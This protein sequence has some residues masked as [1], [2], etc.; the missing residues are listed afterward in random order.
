MRTMTSAAITCIM[1]RM[2]VCA[3]VEPATV[4]MYVK[5]GTSVTTKVVAEMIEKTRAGRRV[6]RA[7]PVVRSRCGLAS[8]Q[9]TLRLAN[10]FDIVLLP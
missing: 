5:S 10:E 6:K 4:G 3:D 1:T 2:A 7:R 8:A 9:L